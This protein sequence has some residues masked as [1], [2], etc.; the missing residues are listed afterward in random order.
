MATMF[1]TTKFHKLELNMEQMNSLAKNMAHVQ[2][3]TSI[4]AQLDM[5]TE[6]TVTGHYT[7]FTLLNCSELK[8]ITE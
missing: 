7:H 6:Q 3:K 5:W 8:G 4:Q 1:T 2:T